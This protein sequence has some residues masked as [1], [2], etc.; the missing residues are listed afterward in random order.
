MFNV[1][2]QDLVEFGSIMQCDGSRVANVVRGKFNVS[3]NVFH[4][5]LKKSKNSINTI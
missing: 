5:K 4:K 1:V 2:K 3:F